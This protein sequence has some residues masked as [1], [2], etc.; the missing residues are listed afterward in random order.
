MDANRHLIV[1]RGRRE[2]GKRQAGTHD[3]GEGTC[4]RTL[5]QVM[6]LRQ[7]SQMLQGRDGQD[8]WPQESLKRH[9]K[10]KV[11]SMKKAPCR[12]G[13]LKMGRRL[14]HVC[15]VIK[16]LSISDI[17]FGFLWTP[18]GI[19]G[20]H[21]TATESSWARW[22][23]GGSQGGCFKLCLPCTGSCV[24]PVPGC[25]A[26]SSAKLSSFAANPCL[27]YLLL[28]AGTLTPMLW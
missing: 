14:V 15:K 11:G 3:N 12:T 28:T 23:P 8:I 9:Q 17:A 7:W 2:E 21:I 19:L 13:G 20:L 27:N 5:A 10:G 24:R 6:H 18:Q 22:W 1:V 25:P 26:R 16:Q 4:L